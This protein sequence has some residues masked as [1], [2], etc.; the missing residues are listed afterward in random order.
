MAQYMA[1][2]YTVMWQD[3]AFNEI[4]YDMKWFKMYDMVWHAIKDTSH[5]TWYNWWYM[6]WHEIV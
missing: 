1:I 4:W 2:Y 3:K 5:M 6:R